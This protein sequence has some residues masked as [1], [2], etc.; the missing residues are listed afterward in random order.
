MRGAQQGSLIRLAGRHLSDD[1]AP[2]QDDRP[3]ANQAYF[4]KLGREQ[5]HG[6]PR[7]GHLSQQPIDLM[8]GADIDAAGRIEAKQGLKAGG[9]PSRDHHLLLV[10]AAQPPQFG[11]RA[12]VDLQALHGGATR[13]RS[14][15]PRMS[16]Q[17]DGL[18]TSGKATFS[19]I[20]RCGRRA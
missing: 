2:E 18:R 17:F 1:F 12:G 16:P 10:A 20:E 6:R 9:N 15:W 14:L 5:Q 3:V 13:W 19:R 8:L 7:V 4:R 11:P